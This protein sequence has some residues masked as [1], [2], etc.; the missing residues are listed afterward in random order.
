V[1]KK[2]HE[3]TVRGSFLHSHRHHFYRGKKETDKDREELAKYN[4]PLSATGELGQI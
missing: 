3:S 1:H 2:G 4:M